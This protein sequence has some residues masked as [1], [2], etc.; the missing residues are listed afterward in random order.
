MPTIIGRFNELLHQLSSPSSSVTTTSAATRHPSNRPVES[1]RIHHRVHRA[2]TVQPSEYKGVRRS[3][4]TSSSRTKATLCKT[5]RS[6]KAE[7][8]STGQR[9]RHR[10][11]SPG[12]HSNRQGSHQPSSKRDSVSRR[13]SALSILHSHNSR[14]QQLGAGRRRHS[15]ASVTSVT[16][17]PNCVPVKSVDS[18]QTMSSST[19]AAMTTKVSKRSIINN[20]NNIDPVKASVMNAH[21]DAIVDDSDESLASKFARKMK[22]SAITMKSYPANNANSQNGKK[23]TSSQSKKLLK[24]KKSSPEKDSD[25]GC[26]IDRYLNGYVPHIMLLHLANLRFPPFKAFDQTPS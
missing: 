25:Q 12:N 6:S 19:S 3:N 1:S 24:S 4:S 23:S 21:S 17:S 16:A 26:F 15:I 11:T 9:V 10:Q 8:H 2:N 13:E 18:K 5:S 22:I 14:R 20:N 7:E